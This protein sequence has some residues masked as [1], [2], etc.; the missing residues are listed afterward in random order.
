MKHFVAQSIRQHGKINQTMVNHQSGNT[1]VQINDIQFGYQKKIYQFLISQYKR[2][3]IR[4]WEAINQE[5]HASVSLA[6][7]IKF[8]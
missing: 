4:K 8:F 1:N 3:L 7:R 2:K 6:T 5:Q